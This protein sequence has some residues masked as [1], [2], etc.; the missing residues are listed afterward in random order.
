MKKILLAIITGATV[1]SLGT[2]AFASTSPDGWQPP[3]YTDGVTQ[4]V[5]A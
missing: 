3:D 4:P 5:V 1:L 2:P